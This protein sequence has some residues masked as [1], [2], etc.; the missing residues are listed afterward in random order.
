VKLFAGIDG[1]QS[2]T[3]AVIGD[4]TGRVLAR[5]SA[6]AADEVG[7]GA[8]STRL[9][10]ALEAALADARD[11]AGLPTKACFTQ[12]VAGISGYE[13]RVYGKAPEFL[14]ECV[15]LMHDAPI[16]HAGALGGDPG[17]LVIAGTGSVGYGLNERGETCTI[18]GW[19]YLFG[20]QGSAFA[21]VRDAASEAM[22]DTDA[23]CENHLCAGMLAYFGQ[24]SLRALSRAFYAGDI[25]R[26]RLAGFAVGIIGAAESGD[27]RAAAHC[28]SSAQALVAL[29][30]ATAAR[31]AMQEPRVAFVGGLL[32]SSLM[33]GEIE[34]QLARRFPAARRVEPRYDPA[35]GALLLAYKAEGVA[36]SEITE[37]P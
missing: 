26:E 24:P 1:G 30:S 12:V 17:V 20:D 22:R 15:T 16:A 35:A 13:G 34:A 28:R 21:L 4:E 6:V 31:L 8:D 33:A 27:E 37:V 25:S 2:S 29:A 14:A 7:Q 11:R 18:G 9:R 23:A 19:G 10:D 5:G 32:R 3:T 36:V